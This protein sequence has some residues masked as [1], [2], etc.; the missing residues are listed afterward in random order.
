MSSPTFPFNVDFEDV[1]ELESYLRE[2][3]N[4]NVY[5]VTE[6]TLNSAINKGW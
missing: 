4:V 2:T 3:A 1:R 5:Q 6:F